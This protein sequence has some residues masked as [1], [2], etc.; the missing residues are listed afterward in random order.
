LMPVFGVLMFPFP[1]THGAIHVHGIVAIVGYLDH[2]RKATYD[3]PLARSDRTNR[4]LP[5]L[6]RQ[7]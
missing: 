3:W 4:V 7:A 1:A 2:P 6:P 5:D